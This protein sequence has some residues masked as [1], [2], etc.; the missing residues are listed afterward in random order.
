[1]K[2]YLPHAQLPDTGVVLAFMCL[3]PMRGAA[4]TQTG[5][6]SVHHEVAGSESQGEIRA[7]AAETCRGMASSLQLP[8]ARCIVP[9]K[10][11]PRQLLH[12]EHIYRSTAPKWLHVCRKICAVPVATGFGSDHCTLSAG[13]GRK[14]AKPVT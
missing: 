14:V 3:L 7:Q 10:K 11:V 12:L 13:T 2:V 6:S 1:M 4:S 9:L 5:A 8:N